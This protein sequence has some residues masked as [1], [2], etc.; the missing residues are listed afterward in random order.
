MAIRTLSSVEDVLKARKEYANP[1]VAAP[2]LTG[3]GLKAFV[4]A[5]EFQPIGRPL[6]GGI[7][8]K[9]KTLETLE[10][11]IIPDA[12]MF[13]PEYTAQEITEP[14]VKEIDEE[15]LKSVSRVQSALECLPSPAGSLQMKLKSEY[16]FVYWTIRDYAE[17]FASGHVT[18]SEV[19]ERFISAIDK[20]EKSNP[21]MAFL[22][23]F[24]PDDIRKQAE[25]STK[26]HAEGKPLSILDGTLFAVKDDIDCM[27]H[28]STGGTT[29]LHNF[30]EVKE[31]AECVARLRKAG[32]V[33]VGKTN[34]SE[35]GLGVTGHNAHYG[36]VRNP[37]D[38]DRHTGGSSAG[39]CALVAAGLVSGAL[40]TDVGGSVRIPSG[41]CGT[42]GLKVTVGRT[43]LKGVA[44]VGWTME[45]VGP[46]ASSVEDLILVYS[47][48]LGSLPSDILHSRPL[49]PCLPNL[50]DDP[51]SSLRQLKLG[52]FS[53]W[54][55]DVLD[56]EIA[57]VC[58]KS[59]N[60]LQEG[61]GT[62]TKEVFLPD[63]DDL[64]N[65]HLVTCGGEY[66]TSLRPYYPTVKKQMGHEPRAN[67]A[68]FYHFSSNDY[69]AGQQLRRRQMHYHMEAFKTVDVIV[70]PTTAMV[71]PLISPA[72]VKLGESD[73]E[74]SG[75]LMRFILAGNLL[76]LPCVSVPVGHDSRGLP[77]GLQLIGRPWEEATLLRVASAIEE[78]C[79]SLMKRPKV[80]HDLL[81]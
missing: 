64:R 29:W 20:C 40:G 74:K 17:A 36:C 7:L 6:L 72:S 76:G 4:W 77:I 34:M 35:L 38:T 47:A 58:E 33:F 60:L 48:F 52:K 15:S 55:K 1:A 19:A 23:S 16:P 80:F 49:P 45:S 54:F 21:P 5:L 69:V 14:G 13:Y 81:K 56:A 25:A 41:I 51:R 31:D 43:T 9:N 8:K 75:N 73:L 32:V 44:S 3:L 68:L 59:L 22:I 26:R 61:F 67:L 10:E 62:E 28:P 79:S 50:K 37:H 53:P 71:A 30:R 18:P 12:P 57:E 46:I 2:K 66:A 42:V 63:L 78:V 27:P 24:K 11:A 39:S 65:G 70:T